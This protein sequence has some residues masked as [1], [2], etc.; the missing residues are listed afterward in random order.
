MTEEE[1]RTHLQVESLKFI[2]LDGL[3]RACGEKQ[4]RVKNALKYCDACFSSEYPID[5]PEQ[6]F[7]AAS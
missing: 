3:Y 6:P 7:K 5:I 4:G 2:T 1:M